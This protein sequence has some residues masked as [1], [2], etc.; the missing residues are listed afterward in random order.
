M[1]GI[2]VPVLL[3]LLN[4]WQLWQDSS[5]ES[6]LL[7]NQTNKRKRNINKEPSLLLCTESRALGSDMTKTTCAVIAREA[8]WGQV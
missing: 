3:H 2:T 5:L 8:L 1:T 7:R 4:R 6:T